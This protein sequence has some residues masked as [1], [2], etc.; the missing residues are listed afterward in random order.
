M[1]QRR[2]PNPPRQATCPGVGPGFASPSDS[3]QAPFVFPVP[4]DVAQPSNRPPRRFQQQQEATRKVRTKMQGPA[5]NGAH[6]PILK[7]LPAWA[8]GAQWEL[9]S[10]HHGLHCAELNSEILTKWSSER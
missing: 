8:V 10:R 3:L 4:D 6:L 1:P 9:A 2:P 5:E 7:R